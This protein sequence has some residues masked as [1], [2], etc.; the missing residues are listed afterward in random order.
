MLVQALFG[1]SHVPCV[2]HIVFVCLSHVVCS[3]F[4]VLVVLLVLCSR[5]GTGWRSVW[6]DAGVGVGLSVGLVRVWLKRECGCG[7]CAK[8]MW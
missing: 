1:L 2:W 5:L 7:V 6:V 3:L 8:V 4:M